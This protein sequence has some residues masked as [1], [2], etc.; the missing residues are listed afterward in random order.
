MK[1]PVD[2]L[3]ANVVGC[4]RYQSHN[5]IHRWAVHFVGEVLGLA[6]SARIAGS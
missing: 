5:R 2:S 3:D 4:R 1:H 6:Q